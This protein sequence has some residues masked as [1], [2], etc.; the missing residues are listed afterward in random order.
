[1]TRTTAAIRIGRIKRALRIPA[2]NKAVISLWRRKDAIVNIA[3]TSTNNAVTGYL[4]TTRVINGTGAFSIGVGGTFAI[5][6][7]QPN[8]LYSAP[9]IVTAEYQ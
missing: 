6:A 2:L 7:N 8:G 4:E 5:A 3:A 9:F 1:M